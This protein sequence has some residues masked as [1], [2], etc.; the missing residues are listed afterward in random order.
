MTCNPE[1]R[2]NL[3][4]ELTA[5]RFLGLGAVIVLCIAAIEAGDRFGDFAGGYVYL[6]KAGFFLT[7]I[8]WGTRRVGPDLMNEVGRHSNDWHIAHFMNPRNVEPTVHRVDN[9]AFQVS[10]DTNKVI[11]NSMAHVAE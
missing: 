7:T 3:W 11:G 2:R 1:F 10:A 4:L 6:G 9:G 8:L 5:A